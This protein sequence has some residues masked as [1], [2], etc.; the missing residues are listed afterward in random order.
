MTA[1]GFRLNI[2]HGRCGSDLDIAD[3]VRRIATLSTREREVLDGLP[4]GRTS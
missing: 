4:A 2:E 1:A 3:A